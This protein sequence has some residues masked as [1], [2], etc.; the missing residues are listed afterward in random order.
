[1]ISF[2][3]THAS[4]YA[5]I[6]DAQMGGKDASVSEPGRLLR[7]RRKKKTAVRAGQE[8]KRNAAA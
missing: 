2:A 8:Q 4:V 7:Q 3:L 1:M 6:L 5:V